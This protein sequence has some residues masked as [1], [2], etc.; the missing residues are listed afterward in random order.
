MLLSSS[1][2]ASQY[3]VRDGGG[4]KTQC[5]GKTNHTLAGA[6]G[7]NCAFNHPR[8]LLGWDE[9]NTNPG[10]MVSGDTGFID[11]DSDIN[12]GQQA[13]YLIGNDT[14]GGTTPT[15][16]IFDG[17]C[18][19]YAIPAG[20]LGN[21]TS[22]I[23]TGSHKPQLYGHFFPNF[24][25]DATNPFVTLQWLEITD[26]DQCAYNL[27][28]NFC[29]NRDSG[30][31]FPDGIEIGGTNLIMTDVYVHGF[32]RYGINSPDSITTVGDA[33]FTRLWVIGNGLSGFTTGVNAAHTGTW[34]F[35]QPIIDW[36]GCIEKYP[37]TGGVDNPSNYFNCYGQAGTGTGDGGN[38]D[39][40]AFGPNGSQNAGNWNLFG[41]GSISFNTQDGFD[42]L[43]G[44]GNGTM[45]I[46]K[47]RFEGN[48]GQQIKINALNSYITNNFIFGDCGWWLGA[49]Q[50]VT[51]GMK[52]GDV[53]RAGGDVVLFNVT[54]GSVTKIYNNTI[55][56]NGNITLESEDLI[57]FNHSGTVGCN[58]ATAIHVYNN[59]VHGGYAWADDTSTTGD[60]SKENQQPLYIYNDGNDGNGTG[61]CGG[62]VWDEDY[63][64]VDQHKGSN[65]LCVGSHDQC[66]ASPGFTGTIP[67]GTSGGAANTYYQGQSGI[68]LVP[69]SGASAALG[70]GLNGLTFWNNSND[71][72]NLTRVNPP[73]LGALESSS[74][75]ATSFNPCFFNTDC[76]GGTCTSNV[77]GG[78][79]TNVGGSCSSGSTC[80]SGLCSAGLCVNYVCGDSLITGPEACDTSGPNLGGQ[81]CVSRGFSGGSLGCSSGCLSFNTSSCFTIAGQGDEYV[82]SLSISGVTL[83]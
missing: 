63:N 65:A 76:C 71:Y 29:V 7:T 36:N 75:A 2:N 24:I 56:S 44:A 49:T 30:N 50:S 17:E 4:T 78:S 28:G 74:C 64:I 13:Q 25:I 10:V 82:G 34:T 83:K 23:G 68:T 45:Q 33:T 26:H 38:G 6:S 70:A 16:G 20:T 53:C 72:Y 66:G 27:T 77:C 57:D 43:H 19:L 79:C 60:G 15:C 21:P 18:I 35:N 80:C 1:V 62:L 32:G 52:F 11:G 39:G 73:S 48:A 42:T 81:N 41:P 8:W 40:L 59:I 9:F 58:G 37:L 54:N 55:L 67:M 51:G 46:D 5:D 22:I 69:L 61:T 14:V 47:I 3:W 31:R 12:P